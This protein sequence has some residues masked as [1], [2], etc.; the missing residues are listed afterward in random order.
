MTEEQ[1]EA[2][3]QLGDEAFVEA[4]HTALVREDLFD[5]VQPVLVQDL[6]DDRRA[7]VLEASLDHVAVQIKR[8]QGSAR[9]PMPRW[10]EI[11]HM[12]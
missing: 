8:P 9:A 10:M 7:L 11:S 2:H 6:A 5:A 12:G 1:I 4:R 3:D